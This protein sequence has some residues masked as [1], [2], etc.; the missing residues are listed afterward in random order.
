[1]LQS[2]KFVSITCEVLL[3]RGGFLKYLQSNL[4]EKGF[5]RLKIGEDQKQA[6]KEFAPLYQVNCN[7]KIN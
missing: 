5:L 1:M 2:V 3:F 4:G 7:H 6:K